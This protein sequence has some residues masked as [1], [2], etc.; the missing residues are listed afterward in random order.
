MKEKTYSLGWIYR[1]TRG[2]RRYLVYIALAGIASAFASLQVANILKNFMDIAIGDTSQSLLQNVLFM[3]GI[4]LLEGLAFL[5]TGTAYQVACSKV[6]KKLRMEL[7][8]RLYQSSLLEM[9]SHHTGEYITNL[10]ADVE[11][12][13]GCF[14][15]LIKGTVGN[16]LTAIGAV[17]FL[18]AL[19]W[20]L[21]LL[22]LICIPLLILCIAVFSPMMQKMSR[23]DRK[24]EENIR[25][26]F[27][28]VLDKIA[29][30][31]IGAMGEKLQAK[32]DTLLD[33][34]IRSAKG[35]GLAE[36][37]SNFLNNMMGMAMM[38]IAIG[39]GA[40]FVTRGELLIS[41]MIAIV[42]L[43]N[44]IIWPFTAIGSM[45]SEVN[46][47]IVSA[48]RLDKI[49]SLP[50]EQEQP[51]APGQPVSELRLTGVS[52]SYGETAV[53]QDVTTAF[54]KNRL[55]AIVGES[56][57]GK[58]T[59]LKLLSGLYQPGGGRV[60]AILADGTAVG[61]LRPY[62]GLVPPSNLVFRDSIAA[63]LAMALQPEEAQLCQSAAMANISQYI[64]SLENG[65]DTMIGDGQ[66]ALSSGQEQRLGI[67]RALYQQAEV[68]LFDEPTANL[69]AESIDV[70]LETL[71]Q[72]AP[73]HICLVVTHDPRV[74]Q[75]CSQ[76]LEL[77]DHALFI[78]SKEAA[79]KAL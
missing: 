19:N 29:L 79:C 39:G 51:K 3:V 38:L 31:K 73:D 61:N 16:G 42:Q 30:F 62:V 50:L 35:L 10:T 8:A 13:S 15:G 40:Y 74:I 67:A 9:Q 49:Y 36:G 20:K 33:A 60:E 63:N 76:V 47:S 48:Q 17:V 22:L 32:A 4:T 52:F 2:S 1:Q 25:V 65:Y 43:S 69:D 66:Q 26:Y 46:Q 77:R 28:D 27:Q 58:S 56:G 34:K 64:D 72:I 21:A 75:R 7:S 5:V 57:G 54:A 11:K 53:L 68:L 70:F 41:S 55:T 45:I 12:V 23:K 6:S 44:Y 24:N 37:G 18:F 14:S 78:Q 59:L 71:E